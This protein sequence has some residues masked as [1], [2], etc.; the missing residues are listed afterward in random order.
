M[1]NY[2]VARDIYMYEI[3]ISLVNRQV[4]LRFF[5]YFFCILWKIIPSFVF[6]LCL[7]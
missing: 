3:I 6:N 4:Q 7:L 2:Q 1:S 5:Y